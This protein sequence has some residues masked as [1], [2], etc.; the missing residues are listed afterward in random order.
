MQPTKYNIKYADVQTEDS[1][2]GMRD[3][4]RYGLKCFAGWGIL[5]GI[6]QSYIGHAVRRWV[7]SR[8][9]YHGLHACIQCLHDGITLSVEH[10]LER[11]VNFNRL[12]Q[13]GDVVEAKSKERLLFGDVQVSRQSADPIHLSSPKCISTF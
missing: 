7:C 8:M 2:R 10:I 13:D 4:V 9:I 1:H 11:P 6:T 12:F 3:G 5:E